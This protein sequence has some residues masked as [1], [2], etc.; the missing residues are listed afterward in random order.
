MSVNTTSPRQTLQDRL[1]RFKKPLKKLFDAKTAGKKTISSILQSFSSDVLHMIIIILCNIALNR[2]PM[3]PNG[4][5]RLKRRKLYDQF[6][7]QFVNVKP[8]R[9]KL[10]K[11]QVLESYGPLLPEMLSPIFEHI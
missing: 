9:S 2:I 7:S 1:K 3:T 5:Q 6:L 8:Y 11:L 10:R 4:V